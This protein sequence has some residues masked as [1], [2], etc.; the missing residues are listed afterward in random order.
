MRHLLTFLAVL[1]LAF[2]PAPFLKSVPS[3]HDL[4]KLQG[5]WV[6]VRESHATGPP[7]RKRDLAAVIKG[8][9]VTFLPGATR[10][11]ESGPWPLR[12]GYSRRRST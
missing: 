5:E 12:L 6:L 8:G 7:R 2:A 1:C 9:R 11:P 10:C 3:K 4:K